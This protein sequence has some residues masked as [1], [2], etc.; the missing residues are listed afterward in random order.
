MRFE[1]ARTDRFGLARP[2][3]DAHTLGVSSIEQLLTDCGYEVASVDAELSEAFNQPQ[4]PRNLR[5]IERWIR[6]ERI[7]VLGLSY[8]LDP[9][10]GAA[11]FARLVHQLKTA[12][13]LAAQGGPIRGL[14]F[15]GLPLACTMVEQQNPEV[16]GVFRGD[17]TPAET[18]RILR[19][20]PRALPADLAQ[21]VRYDEDRLSFGKDLIARGE[22]L[23][24]KPA[25]R[26][27]YEG[28]GTERDTLLARLR[29]HAEHGLPPLMRAHVGPYLPN[30]D[31]AVQL[32]LQWCRQLAASGHL[33]VLSVGTSQLSQSHFGE[34][35]GARA[36]GGGVPLNSAEEFAAVWEAARPMLVRTYAAT[37]NI[38]ELARMY[39]RTIHIA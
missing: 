24:V 19:I 39:E 14:F 21:G 3:V 35:W 30:R 28:F 22:H 17:E 16:S 32:F 38:P 20:D 36:N 23:Q 2:A 33:D 5:A 10:G 9:A 11:V 27:S 6:Q 13:L 1:A 29:H 8:R 4:D 15:A 7:T 12:R 26:G 25:D 18:L 31:Q 37:R 34:D